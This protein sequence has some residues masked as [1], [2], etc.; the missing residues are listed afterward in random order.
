LSL[1]CKRGSSA[2]SVESIS[3]KRPS[4]A[5]ALFAASK[6]TVKT[7]AECAAVGAWASEFIIWKIV[8]RVR[9]TLGKPDEPFLGKLAM[10]ANS[11]DKTF[12][13]GPNG[14]MRRQ[15]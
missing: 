11:R 6:V 3:N 5:V 2:G 10:L 8:K 1:I 7:G 9:Q 15:F 14:I 12:R 13:V 4:S